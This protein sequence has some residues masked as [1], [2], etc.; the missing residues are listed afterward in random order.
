[1]DELSYLVKFKLDLSFQCRFYNHQ[2]SDDII[3]EDATNYPNYNT[4]SFNNVVFDSAVNETIPANGGETNPNFTIV[5]DNYNSSAANQNDVYVALEFKNNGDAF[6]GKHNVIGSGMKSYLVAKLVHNPD[7]Q[8]I[9][10]PTE[11]Q[12]P[13][14]Y[15][16]SEGTHKAGDS[17]Q[18]PRVFIQDYVTKAVFKISKYALQNAYVTMPDMS[19][20]QMS[21]GLSVDI[22]WQNGFVYDIDFANSPF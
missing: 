3:Y 10:W 4:S 17:M 20:A 12:I 1:M 21:L 8:T 19:Q 11:F 9:T 22:T 5:P 14:L 7:G 15:A 6:W 2:H 16:T 18:I 13:P